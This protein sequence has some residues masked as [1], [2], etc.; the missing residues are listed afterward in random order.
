MLCGVWVYGAARS[1]ILR[2]CVQL[3]VAQVARKSTRQEMCT[4]GP[5]RKR[6]KVCHR[7]MLGGKQGSKEHFGCTGDPMAS[8]WTKK[9]SAIMTCP[10]PKEKWCLDNGGRAGAC[11]VTHANV[12]IP[13][14]HFLWGFTAS[15]T[16]YTLFSTEGM[17]CY[18]R[19]PTLK[20]LLLE[21]IQAAMC[22][23]TPMVAHDVCPTGNVK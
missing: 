12:R 4:I 17:V 5:A 10:N 16:T 20:D 9:M 2:N 21:A 15:T 14:V 13:F 6:A 8:A 7:Y 1:R 22:R 23:G 11:W 18:S 19:S 3:F